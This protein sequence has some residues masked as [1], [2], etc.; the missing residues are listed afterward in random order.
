MIRSNIERVSLP[1]HQ[2]GRTCLAA[3]VEGKS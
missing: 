2:D 3:R 1:I